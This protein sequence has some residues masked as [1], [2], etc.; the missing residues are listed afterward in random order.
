MKAVGET[1]K[2]KINLIGLW[3]VEKNK[4]EIFSFQVVAVLTSTTRYCYSPHK[5]RR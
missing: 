3:V 2:N 5:R 1:F 4:Q